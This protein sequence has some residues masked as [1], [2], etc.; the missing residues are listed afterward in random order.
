MLRKNNDVW[1]HKHS[2][3][4]FCEVILYSR[5][6]RF[7]VRISARNVQA[8]CLGRYEK[9]RRFYR[10]GK[11]GFRFN[12]FNLAC[13]A[14]V[15]IAAICL[16]IFNLHPARKPP[17][18]QQKLAV[19]VASSLPKSQVAGTSNPGSTEHYTADAAN[20]H[21]A[22]TGPA[23]SVDIK[24][25]HSDQLKIWYYISDISIK[26]P[27]AISSGMSDEVD[28]SKN[29]ATPGDIATKCKAVFSTNGDLFVARKTGVIIRNGKLWRNVP[30]EPILAFY[31]SGDMKVFN[32]TEK[33]AQQFLAEGV[34]NT[35]AFGPILIRDGVIDHANLK[36]N[37]LRPPNPRTGI[38]T[39]GKN[40]FI[41]IVV[42]GRQPGYSNGITLDD[43]AMLF[44]SLGCQT[45]YNLDGGQ[46]SAVMFMGT[47]LNS[48]ANDMNG[49][50][51]NTYRH[52]SEVLIFGNSQL[53]P[54]S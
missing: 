54:T 47:P 1:K 44:Q 31:S 22:Y 18:G 19:P 15:I 30:H 38:G 33:T 40:H 6:E 25:V 20:N 46:S 39:V 28:P 9:R 5:N 2:I 34:T 48:H 45:A 13:I 24:K 12:S 52:V 11:L 53:I 43:F 14:A 21:W 29:R 41:S 10:S 37:S 23:L 7:H 17:A 8:A 3:V 49:T 16:G 51:W 27:K 36:Q 35:F 26:D 50:K 42:E 32:P 4:H